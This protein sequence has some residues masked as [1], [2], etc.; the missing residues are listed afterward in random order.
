MLAQR[1]ATALALLA[2][3]AAAVWAGGAALAEVI[4]ILLGAATYEWLRLAGHSQ[5]ASA[6]MAVALAAALLLAELAGW[7]PSAGA[8]TL[9]LGGATALWLVLAVLVLSAAQRTVHIYPAASTGLAVVLLAAAWFAL[10]SLL[11]HG[12]PWLVSALARVWLAD[13]AAYFSGRAVGRRKLAPAI[14]PGKTWEGVAGAM[15]AVVGLALLLAALLPTQPLFS[16]RLLQALGVPL[17]VLVL[18]LLVAMSVVGDLFESLLKRQA[19]VK[20]S[21]RLLPGHG[22]V[23]DR[24]D[25]LLPVLPLAALVQPGLR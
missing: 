23:L 14:S 19:G 13:I 21:G 10:L 3:L 4:A 24:I 20:D 18:M 15:I 7:Q 5:R 12:L 16:T 9:I 6:A 17:G 25:A 22:G 8:V 1:V 11:S 2:I